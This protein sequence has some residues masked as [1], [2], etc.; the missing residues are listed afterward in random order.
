MSRAARKA[1]R[2]A[3][4]PYLHGRHAVVTGGGRGIGAAI[5][6]ELARLG[7]RLT[8][9]GRDVVALSRQA[10]AVSRDFATEATAVSCDVSDAAAVT[11]AFATA[12][13]RLGDA[14]ILVNNAGQ[15]ESAPFTETS[16]E[17]WDR[18]LAVN[19]TGAYLCTR[20]VLP[21]MLAASDG[22]IVNVA[23]T[24]GLRGY[25]RMAAYC[26]AKH[27]LIGLTRAL[28]A[29]TAK[30]SVTVNAV[31]PGYTDT[32][33]AARGV[34]NLVAARGIT[35][36]EALQM[37]TRANPIGRLTRPVEV[38]SAVGWLCSP[39]AAAMTGQSIAVAGGEVM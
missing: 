39:D 11:E 9:M 6:I 25:S 35:P 34:A 31:C 3:D 27:G 37:L 29:E 16:P 33:M 17:L 15:A 24:A 7:A 30:R 2:A 5:A 32:D 8:L 4:E 13:D 18:M 12:R 20:E 23:S 28:A 14:Y 26:A 10:K 36:E 19:L 21:A 1:S 22:R 38:A